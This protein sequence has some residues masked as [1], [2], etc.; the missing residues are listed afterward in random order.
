[1]IN[2]IKS[3][4]ILHFILISIVLL[5]HFLLHASLSAQ[6]RIT[7][8]ERQL[9]LSGSNIAWV[10]FARD[11]GDTV[12]NY[13]AFRSVFDS[14]SANHGNALRWWLHTT[15]H[16]SPSFD[17]TGKANGPGT[18]TITQLQTVLDDAWQRKVGLILCLWS[19]DMLRSTNPDSIKYRNKLMLNDTTYLN[20]YINNALIPIVN[21]LKEHPAIIAWEVFNEAEGMSLEYG[22]SDL[23]SADI[24]MENIQRFVNKVAGA[25]H[26]TDSKS[27]VTTGAWCFK[28]LTDVAPLGKHPSIESTLK[29]M[30]VEEKAQIERDF[31]AK[32]H[33][34]L[35]VEEIL[36]RFQVTVQDKNYYRD[37]R[38][39]AIGG[40]P[41]GT[42]DFYSVHYY[43]W[44][45]TALS[46]FHHHYSYWQLDKPI[47][48]A[49]FFLENTFGVPI[50]LMYR[51]L[52]DNGYAG[53]LTWQWYS[54]TEQ[55]DRTREAMNDLFLLHP[56]DLDVTQT[57]GKIYAFFSSS[58]VID[59]GD[60]ATITWIT[61]SGS[62]TQLDG[63]PVPNRGSL[64]VS[65][66]IASEYTLRTTG[67]VSDT[68]AVRIRLYPRGVILSFSVN[69]KVIA[70]GDSSIVSW[71][72]SYGSQVTLNNVQVN[73]RDSMKVGVQT[74]TFYRLNATGDT[75][76]TAQAVLNVV[77]VEELN[78]AFERPITVYPDDSLSS[79]RLI[80]DGSFV[81]QWTSSSSS[82]IK[83]VIDLQ[84]VYQVNK[85]LFSWGQNYAVQYRIVT[86]VN[87]TSDWKQVLQ[88]LNGTGSKYSHDTLNLV[89]RYLWIQ[90][91]KRL[92][93]NSGYNLN[94]IQVFGI[95]NTTQIID[96]ASNRNHPTQFQ[97]F[98]NYPNPFNPT[99]TISFSVPGEG[100]TTLIIYNLLG[101][102]VYRLFQ[103]E[104][105]PG[106]IYEYKWSG[107]NLSSGVYFSRITWQ[108]HTLTNKILLLR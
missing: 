40:D 96:N 59:K 107:E 30:S 91:D 61:S 56:D 60:S 57:S 25:I 1:M 31:S 108:G 19:F 89:C 51:N 11:I 76:T 9:F 46:P 105:K 49:E 34:N 106:L 71:R 23:T 5:Y 62:S 77:P 21:A 17:T 28:V 48:V 39:I 16:Y 88:V 82:L 47:V 97:L 4:Y 42:L 70:E 104:A 33:F 3:D 22:W 92:S 7:Y 101:E 87:G 38:L 45:G 24:P 81:S 12:T 78:R 2:K 63:V 80:V 93:T 55:R 94:E 27:Q 72:A 67:T 75:S 100:E 73:V 37:D 44:G 83:I 50:R 52:F 8:N 53:A 98:D 65:P 35:T 90:L 74:T 102:E 15:G 14:V 64:I 85:I 29:S 18:F 20:A 79:P 66:T 69:P 10:N 54:V 13:V 43:T 95:V 26:R 84:Q 36:T 86:G 41:L 6:S 68:A 32:Y 58:A 99:T 103:G